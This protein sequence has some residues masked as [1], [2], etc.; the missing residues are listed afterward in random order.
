MKY[1]YTSI[2][3]KHFHDIRLHLEHISNHFKH[4][5]QSSQTLLTLATLF[6][7]KLYWTIGNIIYSR[8]T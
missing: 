1:N 4:T 2:Q 8:I 3:V 5:A 6:N 7:S